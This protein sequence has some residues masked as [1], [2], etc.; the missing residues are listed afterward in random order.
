MHMGKSNFVKRIK[1]KVHRLSPRRAFSGFLAGASFVAIVLGIVPLLGWW[2]FTPRIAFRVGG[3]EN[4]SPIV[5]P[6]SGKILFATLA[7]CCNTPEL[8]EV[9][10]SFDPKAVD[11]SQTEGATLTLTGDSRFP[12]ELVFEVNEE[13]APEVLLGNYLRYQSK[14][15]R[16]DVKI[17]AVAQARQEDLPIWARIFGSNS[18]R[19]E[20]IVQFQGSK[21]TRFELAKLGLPIKPKEKMIICGVQSQ[22]E[23]DCIAP[24]GPATVSVMELLQGNKMSERSLTVP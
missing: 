23:V 20:R 3:E 15:S 9:R 12:T 10:V 8:R 14:Q 18:V 2:Y 16:F 6:L 4:G 13:M 22:G 1:R 19:L 24:Q 5:M 17:S 7:S 11:L 21:D